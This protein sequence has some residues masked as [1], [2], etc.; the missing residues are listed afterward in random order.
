M[1]PL[2]IIIVRAIENF[3]TFV[4]AKTTAIKHCLSWIFPN[5]KL[6]T[7][8]LELHGYSLKLNQRLNKD[9]H[10]AVCFIAGLTQWTALV[11]FVP[12]LFKTVGRRWPTKENRASCNVI[13]WFTA[14]LI[15]TRRVYE[16]L[17]KDL[18]ATEKYLKAGNTLQASDKWKRLTTSGGGLEALEHVVRSVMGT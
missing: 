5:L 12:E 4:K 14:D 1:K 15:E 13:H 8:K 17:W 10:K 2:H 7:S 9:Y 18:T 6:G 16:R 11:R 3:S